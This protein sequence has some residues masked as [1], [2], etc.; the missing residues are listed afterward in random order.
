LKKI[1]LITSA[2]LYQNN[3]PEFIQEISKVKNF[4]GHVNLLAKDHLSFR[5]KFKRPA[6]SPGELYA[7][8]LSKFKHNP[9]AYFHDDV[10]KNE[11]GIIVKQVLPLSILYEYANSEGFGE[12]CY[13]AN[14][15]EP[16]TKLQSIKFECRTNLVT[17]S[18]LVMKRNLEQLLADKVAILSSRP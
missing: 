14:Q 3:V 16:L 2:G 7:F 10:Y 5:N 9:E 15:G 18:P 12:C 8:I 6:R 1:I 13:A 17:S 4:I 11:N